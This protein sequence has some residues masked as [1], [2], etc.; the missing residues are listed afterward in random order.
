MRVL[1][2][3]LATAGLLWVAGAVNTEGTKRRRKIKKKRA[4]AVKLAESMANAPYDTPGGAGAFGATADTAGGGFVGSGGVGGVGGRVGVVTSVDGPSASADTYNFWSG[5]GDGGGGGGERGGAITSTTMLWATAAQT[6]RVDDTAGSES[7]EAALASRV[8][9]AYAHLKSN[10]T[11]QCLLAGLP[12]HGA[13][14]QGQAQAAAEPPLCSGVADATAM[15][16]AF[17]TWQTYDTATPEGAL[18]PWATDLAAHHARHQ[19]VD[20]VEFERLQGHFYA[21]AMRYLATTGATDPTQG[22]RLR[23]AVKCWSN[24]HASGS[25]HPPHHHFTT[26]EVVSGV[27][28]AVAPKGSGGLVSASMPSRVC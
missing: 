14:T 6:V 7:L 17:Y 11:L 15:N 8:T 22:G 3:L 28:F 24:L 10:A 20:S 26:D 18:A 13:T 21:A 27:Y 12:L 19:L 4:E 5:D 16:H 2:G 25:W 1:V 23:L 9:T